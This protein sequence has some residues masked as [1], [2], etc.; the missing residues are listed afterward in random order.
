MSRSH[1]TTPTVPTDPTGALVAAGE[2]EFHSLEK[3]ILGEFTRL[4]GGPHASIAVCGLAADEPAAAEDEVVEFFSS[5]GVEAERM[6]L[7]GA[8]A[9]L[10]R[11]SA[12]WFTGGDERRLVDAL[13]DELVPVIRQRHLDGMVVGGAGAGAAALS[14]S[15][16]VAMRNGPGHDDESVDIDD[17]GL[18]LIDD[19]IDPYVAEWGRMPRLLAALDAHPAVAFGIDE[20][21]A[22]VAQSGRLRVI[23]R[24]A[25]TV[26]DASTP[27]DADHADHDVAVLEHGQGYDIEHRKA[28]SPTEAR[29][30]APTDP[31]V[32]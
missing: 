4:A 20:G 16:L 31:P 1:Q 5:C 21:T 6:R 17:H 14:G 13:P 8:H 26:I 28:L 15:L 24:G 19:L 29:S 23:G 7:D 9:H 27:N 2:S 30:V 18:G 32:H 12:L 25:V 11:A 22:L 3:E 10:M